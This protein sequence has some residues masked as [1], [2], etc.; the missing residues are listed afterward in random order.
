MYKINSIRKGKK[1]HDSD[2]LASILGED[3]LVKVILTCREK[4]VFELVR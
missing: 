2:L 1:F 4:E 3:K